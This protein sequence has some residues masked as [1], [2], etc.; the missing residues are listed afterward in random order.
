MADTVIDHLRPH[1]KPGY[2]FAQEDSGHWRVMDPQGEVVRVAGTGQPILITNARSA[3]YRRRSLQL[4]RQAGAARPVVQKE[5]IST[6]VKP[7]AQV[8]EKSPLVLAKE[9]LRD[10]KS[11]GRERAM[12]RAYITTADDNLKIRNLAQALG[13]RIKELES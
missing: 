8:S 4:L 10:P 6:P 5:R 3:H 13:R 12:A 2:S 1:L 11:S 7:V 9:I